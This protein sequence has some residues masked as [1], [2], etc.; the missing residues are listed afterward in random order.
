MD[1]YSVVTEHKWI[2]EA[3]YTLIIFSICMVIVLKT[4][5]FFRLSFHNGIRYFRN[6]FLFFGFGFL[7]RYLFGFSEQFSIAVKIMFEYF[8]I[9]AGFFLFYSL[10]WKKFAS[11]EEHSSLFNSKII[12]F[13]L[14]A[15]TLAVIDGLW[16]TYNLMFFSQII[17]FAYTSII[18]FVNY[19][20][21]SGKYK[22]LKF[23]FIGMLLVLSAW[24]LNFLAAS[25]FNWNPII[26][27]NIGIIN[28]IFFFLF[29]YG[30]I[31]ATK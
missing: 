21:K 20:K 2:L 14:M 24:V 31:K 15:I 29:L 28:V 6:A 30:V 27:I 8:L 25:V 9:M 26:L 16:Q 18:S 23:Y 5:R 13:H 7:A 19:I 11:T 10:I 4:D 22:F 1:L 3:L 17:I 12:I